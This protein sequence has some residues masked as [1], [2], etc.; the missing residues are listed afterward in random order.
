MKP[1]YTMTSIKM[2]L[3]KFLA[4]F[5]VITFP[6]HKI[7]SKMWHFQYNNKSL[8]TLV[9]SQWMSWNGLDSR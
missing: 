8:S 6:S 1:H 2:H 7:T 5:A 4:I 9:G 3:R